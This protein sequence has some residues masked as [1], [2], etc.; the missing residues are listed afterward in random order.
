VPNQSD[1]KSNFISRS[2]T[3]SAELLALTRDCEEMA[4]Y[5]TDSAFQVG[6]ANAIADADCVGGNAH[7]SATLL[8]A[9]VTIFG[10]LGTALTPA[11]RASLRQASINPDV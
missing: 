6:G 11:M 5:R 2:V 1:R 4:L 3:L 9:V 7:M 10:Q 8:A